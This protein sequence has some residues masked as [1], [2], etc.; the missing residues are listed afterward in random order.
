MTTAPF[1]DKETG[2]HWDIAGRAVDGQLKGWTLEWLDSVDVLWH[3]WSA[4]HPQTT[5]YESKKQGAKKP[6]A[7]DALK[8]IAGTAEFLR[9]VPKKFGKFLTADAKKRTVTVLFE[10]ENA[11]TTWPLTPDAEIKIH[12]WWG[13]LDQR[14]QAG[15]G[16]G[17]RSIAP[18]SPW[19]YSWSATN[20]ASKTSTA[21]WRQDRWHGPHP[22]RAEETR[23][24]AGRTG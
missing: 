21:A 11:A 7:K 10:G 19:H 12:G 20:S 3:A 1:R 5:I 9:A 2:S 8:E 6:N 14:S 18:R 17:S 4:E 16:P 13:R 22:G 24:N 23:A 15:G